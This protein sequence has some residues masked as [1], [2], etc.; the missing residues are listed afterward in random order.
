MI[1][2]NEISQENKNE[3]VAIFN[4][5]VAG[6]VKNLRVEVKR[7]TAEDSPNSPD[8]KL[9]YIDDNGG[10][11]NDGIYY[12][13]NSGKGNPKFALSRLVNVLHS[14]NP[15]T[16][17]KE[18]PQ[19]E[20]YKPAVDFLMKQI[21]ESSKAGRVNVFV[22]YGTKGYPS[23]YLSVRKVNFVE[24]VSADDTVTKLKPA[25]SDDEVKQRYN[26]VLER[27]Q[28]TTFE[29]DDTTSNLP[30]SDELDW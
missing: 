3:E 20:E 6:R 8:Y 17:G 27:I 16:I 23:Q 29:V 26:D 18:L 11:V 7:K 9:F 21:A 24:P 12:P 1:N 14:L 30:S 5:G 15:S 19:F 25:F 4:N 13:D 22:N 10:K 28:E 2:L